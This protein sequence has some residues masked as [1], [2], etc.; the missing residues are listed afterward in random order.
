MNA[1]PVL[2]LSRVSVSYS[3]DRPPAL[4]DV[5]L[6]V[7]AGAITAIL[8]PNGGGKTTLLH[9]LLGWLAPSSGALRVAGRP[10]TAYTRR[11]M[12]RLVGLV[13]QHEHVPFD[14]TLL[15][16]V[17]LGRAPY[18][19]PLALPGPGDRQAAA[20]ALAAVGL[21]AGHDRPVTALSGGERQLAM[22]ARALAQNP[23]ILLLDE[24]TSH[25]DL[26]NRQ[27][28]QQV[29]RRLVAAGL[30][31]VFT[32]HDPQLAE[33]LAHQAVLLRHG[34]LL[35][36]GPAKTIFTTEWQSATYGIPVRVVASG[37]HRLIV[38]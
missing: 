38:S 31:V 2:S 4:R 34:N 35:A 13:P 18:L 26:G 3:P 8:G 11:E 22:I 36:A 21:T 14:F 17:L 32:T 27:A 30:A 25:L 28:V 10:P 15:D 19:A 16:Y 9:V 12:S 23:R 20:A 1:G 6:D 5:S 37:D 33:A 7:S 24:P 29:L